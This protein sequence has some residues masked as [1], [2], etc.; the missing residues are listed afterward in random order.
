MS[1]VI[2]LFGAELS[3][4]NILLIRRYID[5]HENARRPRLCN[6]NHCFREIELFLGPFISIDHR[7]GTRVLS[8]LKIFAYW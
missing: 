6:S 5:I 2:F 3:Y 4:T 7:L 8:G 1:A